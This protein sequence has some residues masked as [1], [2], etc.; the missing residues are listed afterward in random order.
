MAAVSHAVGNAR[1]SKK[2]KHR[3][4]KVH[5]RGIGGKFENN[6]ELTQLFEEYFGPVDHVQVRHRIKNG[7]NH[8][9]ALVT[10]AN[11][12]LQKGDRNTRFLTPRRIYRSV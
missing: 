11:P 3:A 1:S 6:D 7:E 4:S 12:R 2:Q 8:S 10:M 5:V 9:W